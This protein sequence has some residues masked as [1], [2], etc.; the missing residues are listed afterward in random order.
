MD[1]LQKVFETLEKVNAKEIKTIDFEGSSPF[2][3]YFMI[4]TATHTQSNA[5]LG[6][7]KD[8][9]KEIKSE[10]NQT[11][12]LLVDLGDI[13]VHLFDKEQRDYYKLDNHLLGFK[14]L[15][16]FNSK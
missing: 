2:Y 13:V 14:N 8:E 7:L 5:F 4:A 9:F 3:D 16:Q 6:Y 1:K 15:T 11:G 12:W 10:G